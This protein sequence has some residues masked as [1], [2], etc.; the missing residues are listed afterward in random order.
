[1]IAPHDLDA[2]DRQII[3]VLGVSADT[4]RFGAVSHGRLAAR[5]IVVLVRTENLEVRVLR[6]LERHH[7]GPSYVAECGTSHDALHCILRAG[8]VDVNDPEDGGLSG[9]R[10]LDER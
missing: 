3:P 9:D 6:M 10:Y 8:L 4:Y 5:A 2:D 1:M 7:G